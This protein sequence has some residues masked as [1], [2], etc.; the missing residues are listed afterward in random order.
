MLTS[1]WIRISTVEVIGFDSTMAYSIVARA[2]ISRL[3]LVGR[4]VKKANDNVRVF[5]E[6][7]I[8]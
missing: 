4:C 7:L 2:V 1:V 8:T 6:M 3:S 5:S